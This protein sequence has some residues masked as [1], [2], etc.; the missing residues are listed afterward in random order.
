VQLDRQIP[1]LVTGSAGRIGSAAVR[2]LVAA[3]WRARGFDRLPTAGTDEFVVGD[4]TDLAAMQRAVFGAGAVI[5]LAATPDDDDFMTRLLPSNIIGLHH[6]LEAARVGGVK[7]VLLASTGQVVWQQQLEGP[8]AIRADA[9]YSPRHWYSV[10]KIA[11]EMG[12]K[13][14]ARNFAMT[15][16]GVRLGWCPRDK[17]QLAELATTQRGHNTYLSPGD[18]GR[19]FVRAMEADLEP[20]F[21]IVFVCSRPKYK[22]IFDPEPAKRL[23][24]YEPQD[25]WPDGAAE[26]IRGED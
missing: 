24:G 18:A 10:T 4:L 22:A 14:Y 21:S 16:L 6:V 15:V 5:H 23:V 8:H 7:R 20:G 1:I 9:H 11:A 2:A 3:G 25:Q 17:Q 13:A 19:F 26:G 12:G